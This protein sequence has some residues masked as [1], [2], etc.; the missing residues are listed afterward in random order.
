MA[1][2]QRAVAGRQR[3][4]LVARGIVVGRPIVKRHA[5]H[6]CAIGV[7]RNSVEHRSPARIGRDRRERAVWPGERLVCGLVPGVVGGTERTL[8]VRRVAQVAPTA[9]PNAARS[10][11]SRP[12]SPRRCGSTGCARRSG[13]SRSRRRRLLGLRRASAGCSA[14]GPPSRSDAS[15]SSTSSPASCSVRAAAM[16]AA[17]APMT[18]VV[19]MGGGAGK[20]R[21]SRRTG[22]AARPPTRRP[23]SPVANGDR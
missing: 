16:P 13:A 6:R 14:R 2:D 3:P 21:A 8:L 11:R 20:A 5:R 9:V 23:A 10:G 17:P 22:S 19:V 12:L 4:V 15:T 1:G 7:A 18:T